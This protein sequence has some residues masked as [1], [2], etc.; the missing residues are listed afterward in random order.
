MESNIQEPALPKK[1]G[2]LTIYHILY[3]GVYFLFSAIYSAVA[4]IVILSLLFYLISLLNPDYFK[5]LVSSYYV[6]II[7]ALEIIFIYTITAIWGAFILEQK[8][9][10]F[11]SIF[12]ITTKKAKNGEIFYPV[13]PPV[14]DKNT[15][16]MQSTPIFDN[17]PIPCDVDT[18]KKKVVKLIQH[19]QTYAMESNKIDKTWLEWHRHKGATPF[20]YPVLGFAVDDFTI[21]LDTCDYY[22]N[23]HSLQKRAAGREMTG[24]IRIT[25]KKQR[26]RSAESFLMS[27][28]Y[29]YLGQ[30]KKW[31]ITG[32]QYYK[33]IVPSVKK[34]S[35]NWHYKR[36]VV[37]NR[38]D[39]LTL[40]LFLQ[41]RN[42]KVGNFDSEKV[43]T[44]AL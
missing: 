2:K 43:I 27:Y 37:W 9:D 44:R 42:I 34:I 38:F 5:R 30:E 7:L 4:L 20:R 21:L 1:E 6:F 31:I 35:T 22:L 15:S 36:K 25:N 17:S 33:I 32:Y 24:Y 12:S 3:W 8:T 28:P 11:S 29:G 18:Y 16:I 13:T 41:Q 10:M 23:S 26:P 39:W 14:W 40:K 19:M